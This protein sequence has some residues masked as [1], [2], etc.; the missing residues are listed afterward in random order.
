MVEQPQ[1]TPDALLMK[2]EDKAKVED[3]VRRFH[4]E[5]VST[6]HAEVSNAK[7]RSSK[8][9]YYPCTCVAWRVPGVGVCP[10]AYRYAYRECSALALPVLTCAW[11]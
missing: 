3:D 1:Y 9:S 4:E 6:V 8:I 2:P 11:L 5:R 10:A 7:D